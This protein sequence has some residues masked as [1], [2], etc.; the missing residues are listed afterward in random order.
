MFDVDVS[1]KIK[2]NTFVSTSFYPVVRVRIYCFKCIIRIVR[3]STFT[4]FRTGSKLK[5]RC[6]SEYVLIT[7]LSRAISERCSFR[8]WFVRTVLVLSVTGDRGWG[9]R[10]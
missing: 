7:L 4:I 10:T 6:K 5:W 8:L 2:D 9:Y 3:T 1:D